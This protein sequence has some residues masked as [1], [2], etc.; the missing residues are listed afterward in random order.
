MFIRVLSSGS[1]SSYPQVEKLAQNHSFVVEHQHNRSSLALSLPSYSVYWT[2]TQPVTC[3]VNEETFRV[4]ANSF[5]VVNPGQAFQ[6]ASIPGRE[7][8]LFMISIQEDLVREVY[9]DLSNASPRAMRSTSGMGWPVMFSN[10]PQR[11]DAV[12]GP[13]LN[14]IEQALDLGIRDEVW[15]GQQAKMLVERLLYG[16]SIRRRSHHREERPSSSPLLKRMERVKAYM[17]DHFND[18][19]SLESLAE[20]ACVS[21]HHFLRVF[22]RVYGET[23][24]KYLV[25]KRLRAARELLLQSGL[26]ITE[27]SA[28][29]GF[30]SVDGFYRVFRRHYRCSPSEFRNGA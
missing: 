4:E 15:L 23:P 8:G 3:F 19:I 21:Q 6:S 30:Q 10:T 18:P 28:K 14:N 29:V 12:I 20:S 24:Y 17:D 27:I 22:K 1:E 25:Q 13:M 2:S 5:L 7:N 16:E 26:T 11:S 9:T